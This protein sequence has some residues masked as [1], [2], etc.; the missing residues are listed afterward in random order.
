MSL[1]EVCRRLDG[2]PLAIELAA[3]RMSSMA[4][5]EIRD[6]LDHRFQAAR[7]AR[8]ARWDVIRR[9]DTRWR[10]SYDLLDDAEKQLLERCSVFAGGFDL[11]A[12]CAIAPS[13]HGLLHASWIC[14]MRWCASR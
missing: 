11:Q 7:G 10:W 4:V 5:D 14:S 1:R 3:S 9:S 6:H 8:V 13:E 2:I 12:A